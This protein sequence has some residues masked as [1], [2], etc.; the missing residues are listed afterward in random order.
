MAEVALDQ[1]PEFSVIVISYNTREMTLACLASVYAETVGPFEVVVVDNASSDGSAAAIRAQFPQVKLIAEEINH[2]FAKA[3]DIALPHCSTSWFL[4]LNPDTLVLEGALDKLVRFSRERPQ[5]GIWG[6]RTLYA[7][8]R[9]NPTS[10][11]RRMTLWSLIC[12]FTGL[13]AIFPRSDVFNPEAYGGWRRD[14]VRDVDI[15]T[16]CLLLISRA[17]WERLGGFD[18]DFTMYGEEV[19]LCLRAL[20]AGMQPAITPE[21]TIIHYGGASQA[22]RSDKMVRLLKAKA[23]LVKRHFRPGTRKLGIFLLTLWPLSRFLALAALAGLRRGGS[24]GARAQEWLEIWRRRGEW[25]G[26]FR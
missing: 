11:W 8:G 17:S 22:V 7:D 3:H 1:A 14:C 16:G 18:T 6:G 24:V 19:D 13:T 2:G 20:Q 4:L 5:A 12:R 25:V 9:L 21:A 15:V 10:C 26:G 23:E